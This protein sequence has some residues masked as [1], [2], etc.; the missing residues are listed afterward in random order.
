MANV[1]KNYTGEASTTGAVVYTVPTAT[2]AILLG[3]NLANK[4]GV[5]TNVDVQLGTAYLIKNAP[6]PSGSALSVV[7]GKIIVE[8]GEA[9][10]V[11]SSSA[12]SIDAV[13]SVME[14]S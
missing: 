4:T 14:Q 9:I 7:D 3:L 11:T 5:S 10:T 13:L 2:T 12:A 8:A 1:F 6:I